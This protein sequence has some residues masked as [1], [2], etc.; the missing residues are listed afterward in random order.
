MGGSGGVAEAKGWV[1]Q[2]EWPGQGVGG[3]G[4]VAEVKGWVGQGEWPGQGVG[5]SGEW[6]GQ[7]EMAGEIRGVQ[8]KGG[9][10]QGAMEQDTV[11]TV[12]LSSR[13]GLPLTAR[14]TRRLRPSF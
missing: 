10:G 2:R 4:G 14:I 11:Y 9:G 1:G 3:S 8:G 13:L 6:Q 5:G 12:L 7:G